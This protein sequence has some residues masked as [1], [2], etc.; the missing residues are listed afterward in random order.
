MKIRPLLPSDWE[1]VR[2]IY[3]EGI[4]TG[5][6]TFETEAPDWT[7]WDSSHVAGCRIVAEIDGAVIAWAALAPV[8]T[9][10]V[11]RGVGE[12]SVY[13]AERARG[14]GIGEE[15]LRA[16]VEQSEQNGFWTLQAGVF[17][18]NSVSIHIHEQ[19]GFRIVGRR[20]RIGC[21]NGTWR[22]SLLL[23]RRS[24]TIGV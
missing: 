8:S 17:P 10:P 19:C 2:E 14:K 9:R 20:E 21:M 15:L 5:H 6:A 4:A 1:T 7:K 18:E 12:V 16:L 11:Y 24:S 13:V 3:L 22:D 23:E